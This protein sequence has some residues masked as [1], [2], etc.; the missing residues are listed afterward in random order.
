MGLFL[1]KNKKNLPGDFSSHPDEQLIKIY[2]STGDK[3]II[4][5]LFER[6][7]HLV[8]GVCFKYLKDEEQ[9]R[10]MVM[11][12]FEGLFEK[13][14]KYEVSNF[15]SWLHSVTRN[16]C[17][18][19]IRGE[20][21]EK[22]ALEE[23]KNTSEVF[24]DSFEKMHQIIDKPDER[25]VNSLMNAL[26]VLNEEQRQCLELMYLQEKSYK[27]VAFLTGFSLKQVKS[28]IQNGKRNLKKYLGEDI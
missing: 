16:S 11:E 4:G 5:E 2:L 15:K 27:E 28:H 20:K 3:T 19:K 6:Y 25:R 24:M 12:I 23:I 9:C 21:T 10:D 22:N 8:Y 18:M 13:L 1:K 26:A 17:L 14:K 7:T